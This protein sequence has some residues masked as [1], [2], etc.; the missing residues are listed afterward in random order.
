MSIKQQIQDDIKAAM[1]ARDKERLEALRYLMSALKDYEVDKGLR[2]QGIDDE[3]A[4]GIIQSAVKKRRDSIEQFR[5]AGRDDLV[6]RE[7][8][9]LDVISAYMPAQMGEQE[10][11]EL[12]AEIIQSTGASGP[13]DMGKVMGA[14]MPRVK[15]KADGG[16]VNRLVR[17]A[18][19]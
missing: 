12:I 18:L 5:N 9:G 1:K 17:E 2:E 11:R 7:Q 4:L 13:S 8:A 16:M 10:L 3:A 6:A 14:I 19:A 15:G